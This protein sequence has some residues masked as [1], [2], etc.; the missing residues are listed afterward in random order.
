MRGVYAEIQG[1]GGGVGG[2]QRQDDLPDPESRDSRKGRVVTGRQRVARRRPCQL[3]ADIRPFP[4][5]PVETVFS[6]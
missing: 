4:K 1:G 5:E 6:L 3:P 2:A